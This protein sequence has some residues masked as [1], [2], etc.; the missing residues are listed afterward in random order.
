MEFKEIK[1]FSRDVYK[2]DININIIT[3]N[4][5]IVLCEK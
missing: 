1:Y 3:N 2:I 4:T 5:A